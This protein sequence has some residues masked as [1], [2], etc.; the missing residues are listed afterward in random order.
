MERAK[1][2]L[3][4]TSDSVTEVAF[5]S[6]YNNI[7]YFNRIFQKAENCSPTEFRKN[8]VKNADW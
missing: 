3:R 4:T 2:L 1:E 8:R 7:Y 6:G 5:S